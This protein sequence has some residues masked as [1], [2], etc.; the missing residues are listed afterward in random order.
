MSCLISNSGNPEWALVLEYPIPRRG[1]RIDAVLLAGRLVI[2]LEFKC[3]VRHYSREAIDQL[4]D[5]CLDLRDFH[6]ETQ[7]SRSSRSSSRQ[8][9]QKPKILPRPP[10]T[11]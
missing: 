11:G 6:R 2:V 3:G 1:K 4:E 9:H 7:E 10:A 5:Y 8:P